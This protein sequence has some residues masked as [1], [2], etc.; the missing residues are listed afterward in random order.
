MEPEYRRADQEKV[1]ERLLASLPSMLLAW[2]HDSHHGRRIDLETEQPDLAG[3]FLQL[4]YGR[5]PDDCQ[6][7]AMNTSLILYA[8]HEFNASTFAARIAASTL[9][10]FHSAVTAAIGTLRGW[11]HG[12]ANEAALDLIQCF[13]DADE[14]EAGVLEAL[15]WRVKI[16]GFGHRVY[17][18]YDPRCRVLEPWVE[19][20]ADTPEKRRLYDIARRI[21][22]VMWREKRMFPN[23]DFYSAL[24]YHFLDIPKSM[25]TPL[26]VLARITGW[27]AHIIEQRADNRLIRPDAKYIG[28]EPRKFVPLEE[29]VA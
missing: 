19:R 4:L 25:F 2:Y 14:A 27:S 9:S 5:E 1:A 18:T 20:L 16:M 3:H 17:R 28:P 23:V 22:E 15:A 8:E 24:L 12:G 10:D 7:R 21:D 6:R 11:L 26:F 29:R 13:A